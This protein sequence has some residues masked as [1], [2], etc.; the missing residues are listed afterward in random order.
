MRDLFG[1]HKEPRPK[2]LPSQLFLRVNNQFQVV[3]L[4]TH[5]EISTLRG[6][7]CLG[8]KIQLVS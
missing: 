4:K 7:F 1:R 6:K 8:S 3:T 5:Y 2:D